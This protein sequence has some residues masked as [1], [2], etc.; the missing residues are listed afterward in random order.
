M[1]APMRSLGL[2]V[3]LSP[4]LQI[5][6]IDWVHMLSECLEGMSNIL[7]RPLELGCRR[8]NGVKLWLR[9]QEKLQDVTFLF[10]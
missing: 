1:S 7:A 8:C 10:S 3:R 4:K 9:S 2:T 5:K 6:W